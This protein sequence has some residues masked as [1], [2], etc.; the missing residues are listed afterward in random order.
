M[1][2]G[3]IHLSHVSKIFLQGN[4]PCPAL[5]GVNL[6]LPRQAFVAIVGPSGSGKTTLLNLITGIDRPTEG[7]VWVGDWRLDRLSEEDLA[8]WRGQYVG[9]VF[10][11]FQLFPTLTA[12]EN[13]QLPLELHP[14]L[15]PGERRR[16]AWQAL[17]EVGLA[18][19]AHHLPAQLSGGEQQRVALARALVRD[20][21]LLAADEPT[22][23]L[24]SASGRQV[25]DLLQ[26][27]HRRG[28]T[29]LLATHDPHLAG[30]ASCTVHL[31]D[32]RV[33]S[34]N[35]RPPT[36]ENEEDADAHR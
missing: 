29:I 5:Q 23:N 32:G 28:K 9:I 13:V 8:R 2:Q 34:V 18:H 33:V 26:A 6:E 25:L 4:A 3:W 27:A 1:E 16:R 22:G 36:A 11:F 35:S 30:M 17:E 20:P 10:Q 12:L 19:R 31:L 14:A 7:E 21:L 24:D 15:P